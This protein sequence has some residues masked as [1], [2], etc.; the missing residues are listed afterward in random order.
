MAGISET[1]AARH[2][3]HALHPS[4]ASRLALRLSR[5]RGLPAPGRVPPS[6]RYGFRSS[7]PWKVPPSKL[8]DPAVDVGGPP[9][10]GHD[11]APL[12]R[13]RCGLSG[14]LG[15]HGDAIPKLGPCSGP[16][17]SRWNRMATLPAIPV[18][19]SHVVTRLHQERLRATKNENHTGWGAAESAI[20]SLAAR[21][22]HAA[23]RCVEPVGRH[24]WRRLLSAAGHRPC[25]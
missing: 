21:A 24:A 11:V 25:R 15:D 17:G 3:C 7:K 8:L 5:T 18:V 6:G 4:S 19:A 23:A 9:S 13:F 12:R 20:D 14:V 16:L 10:A 1:I 2:P 22:A